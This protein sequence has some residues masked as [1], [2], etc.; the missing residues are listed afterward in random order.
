MLKLIKYL[1][2]RYILHKGF[3]VTTRSKM[4]IGTV[5]EFYSTKQKCLILWIG[6]K[7]TMN[8]F[9]HYMIPIAE[10]KLTVLD[11]Y[12]ANKLLIH[13]HGTWH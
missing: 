6:K 4:D 9:N 1:W 12:F 3:K 11:E 2:C 10:D 8:Y 13:K 7:D 5:V